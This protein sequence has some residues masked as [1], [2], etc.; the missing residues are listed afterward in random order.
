MTFA[1]QS[2]HAHQSG[3]IMGH[4]QVR[5]QQ[6]VRVQSEEQCICQGN[7]DRRLASQRPLNLTVIA[8]KVSLLSTR[9]MSDK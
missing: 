8:F 9:K 7:Y 2:K 6:P 5:G 1:L 3:V 4:L